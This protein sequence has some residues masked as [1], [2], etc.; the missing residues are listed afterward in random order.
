MSENIIQ[1][2][3]TM[4]ADFIIDNMPKNANPTYDCAA[5]AT[6]FIFKPGKDYDGCCIAA[7]VLKAKK[8]KGTKTKYTVPLYPITE[9]ILE[10][11][12]HVVGKFRV[13]GYWMKGV[14]MCIQGNKIGLACHDPR[15]RQ[16]K[17]MTSEE[18]ALLKRVRGASS[19]HVN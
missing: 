9:K 3:L 6:P 18:K 11:V 2:S 14:V 5:D 15:L 16:K 4:K 8:D 10:Q 17:K 7:K 12:S 19:S 13:H 1:R